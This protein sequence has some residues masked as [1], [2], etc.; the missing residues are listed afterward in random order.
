MTPCHLKAFPHTATVDDEWVSM[1]RLDDWARGR[2]LPA[3]VLLKLD[4]QG[5]EREVLDGAEHTLDAVGR[6]L[7]EVSFHELYSGQ[8]LFDELHCLLTRKGFR[9][10]GVINPAFDRSTGAVVQADAIF[11]R[12]LR[13][14]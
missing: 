3:P 13:R 10:S 12:T 6:L 8:A 4:V 14:N 7:V 1:T 2:D 11:E 9:C 5:Y